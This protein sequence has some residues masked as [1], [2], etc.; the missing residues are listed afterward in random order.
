MTDP[1]HGIVWQYQ[2]M[3]YLADNSVEMYD[4][5]NK[6]TFL[7]RCPYPSVRPEHLYIGSVVTV[8]ARQL[9][10]VDYAD[11][12]SANRQRFLVKYVISAADLVARYKERGR[13]QNP[14]L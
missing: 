4:M 3:Y 7:K 11:E 8:Y 9:T 1:H 14:P 5:K 2:L 6:R 10:V 13:K 12:C